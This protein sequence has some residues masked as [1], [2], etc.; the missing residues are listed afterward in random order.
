[1][2]VT[3]CR[4]PEGLGFAKSEQAATFLSKVSTLGSED[5]I[6]LISAQYPCEHKEEAEGIKKW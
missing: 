4:Q 2:E 6:I 1:M 5:A 3:W